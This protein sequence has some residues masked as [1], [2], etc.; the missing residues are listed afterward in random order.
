[1]DGPTLESLR[2]V[3]APGPAQHSRSRSLSLL[4]NVREAI[5][6]TIITVCCYTRSILLLVV[7]VSLFLCL[8]YK[9]NFIVGMYV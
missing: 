2:G 7:V 3:S 8:I 6:V 5:H 4:E 1:M 9:L